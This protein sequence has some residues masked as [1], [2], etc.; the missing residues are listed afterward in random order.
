LRGGDTIKFGMGEIAGLFPS[1]FNATI[2]TVRNGTTYYAKVGD[3]DF[4]AAEPLQLEDMNNSTANVQ[5]TFYLTMQFPSDV[6][7]GNYNLPYDI[8]LDV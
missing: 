5:G 4:N 1:D 6:T 3:Q 2:S 8:G 7:P